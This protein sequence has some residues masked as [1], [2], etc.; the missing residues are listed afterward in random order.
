MDAGL[1]QAL[2]LRATELGFDSSQALL[3]YVSKAVVDGRQIDFGEDD[4]GEP[5]PAAAKRLNHWADE[6]I[7]GKNVSKPFYSVDEFMKDLL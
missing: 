5:T 2:K 6:A 1:R 3:R 7:H 4:W